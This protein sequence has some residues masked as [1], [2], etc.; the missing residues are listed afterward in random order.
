[1]KEYFCFRVY[2][3]R[4]IKDCQICVYRR[5]AQE[6]KETVEK[7]TP[8]AEVYQIDRFDDRLGVFVPVWTDTSFVF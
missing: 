3:E 1:M 4:G 5:S 7:L 8:S 2:Y 6:A